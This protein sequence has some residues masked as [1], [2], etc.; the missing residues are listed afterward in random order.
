M[1]GE[2]YVY[3][4]R[5]KFIV[6]KEIDKKTRTFGSFDSLEEAVFARNLLI[7]HGWDLDEI[8]G[9]GNI[10]EFG[11]EF[12]V[13]TV[14]DGKLKFLAK[15]QYRVE[16]MRN[17][18]SLIENYIKNPFNSRYGT[19]IYKRLDYFD[20]RK[21]IDNKDYLF[22]IYKNLDDATF[23]RDLLVRYDWNLDEISKLPPVQFSEIHNK[24][25]IVVVKDGRIRIT[26]DKFDAES[27]AL[28]NADR[29][30]E[31]NISARYKT[32][33]KNVVFNGNLF[34][35]HRGQHGRITYF[36]SFHEL[37]D[38]VSVRDVLEGFEWDL[39]AIDE[40]RTYRVN[41]YYY[42]FHIFEGTVKIIG[43]FNSLEDSE[44]NRN[45]LSD[46]T[47]EDLYDP[48]NPYSKVNKYITKRGNKFWIKK[49]IDGQVVILGPYD[50]RDEAIDARDSYE[51]NDWNLDLDEESIYNSGGYDD[52]LE[53][54]ISSFTMWQK[55]VY[56]TIVRL[57]KS[58]F[59]FEELI[60]HS[61]IKRYKSGSNFADKVMKHLN[62]LVDFGLVTRIGDDVYQKEF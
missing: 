16:A 29:L 11:D 17:A 1:T 7:E 28:E 47:Y 44:A 39:S 30:I 34:A 53:D 24:F 10:L 14:F 41:G 25:V 51:L 60:G 21:S 9:L 5:S 58:R 4:R 15:F 27:E 19:Y 46:L 50:T 8:A 57:D 52:D 59:T 2:L 26:K 49:K 18:D 45:N 42:R 43:K 35:V 13:F 33:Y 32:G 31:E 48:E 38:A 22:G 61:Y 62:E 6:V 55:I 12:V 20:I 40:D 56:D 37:I 23:A 54:L 3:K 36:G